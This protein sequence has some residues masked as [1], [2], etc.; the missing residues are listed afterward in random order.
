MLVLAGAQV[1]STYVLWTRA[2]TG[3][4]LSGNKSMLQKCG[5][6]SGEWVAKSAICSDSRA[7]KFQMFVSVANMIG[8]GVE[9]E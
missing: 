2:V 4:L 9:E 6:T 8:E 7:R 5:V 1:P 3:T